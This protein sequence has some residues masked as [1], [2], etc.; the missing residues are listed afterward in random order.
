MSGKRKV[1]GRQLSTELIVGVVFVAAMVLLAYFTIILS[2]DLITGETVTREIDFPYIEAIAKGDKVLL[3]GLQV[4]KVSLVRLSPEDSRKV[5]VAIML[6]KDRCPA[7][8]FHEDYKVEIRSSSALGGHHVY[9]ELG[10]RDKPVV[11]ADKVLEGRSPPDI[12]GVVQQLGDSLGGVIDDVKVFT[13]TLRN[14]E[15]TLYRLTSEDDLYND[16]RDLFKSLK[17]A[18]EM[19]AS[20]KKTSDNLNGAITDARE[21]KGTIGKLLTDDSL[22][23]ELKETI[24]EIKKAVA[25]LSNKKST[26]GKLLGDDGELYTSL[27]GAFDKLDKTMTEAH[28]VVAKINRGEGT[29]G[30]LVNDDSL[31]REAKQAIKDV[32]GAIDDFREQ[33]P[34]LTFSSFIFGAL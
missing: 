23:K 33:A 12:F 20:I 8:D 31:F 15:S 30:K 21:G 29:L 3:R 6:D 7:Y 2:R 34:I 28:E 10:S 24:A 18:D 25:N 1:S 22:H 5:R 32:Q 19:I 27:K 9:M 14:K 11:A 17:D 16:A 26:I 4:G 13:S